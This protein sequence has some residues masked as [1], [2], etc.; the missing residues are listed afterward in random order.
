MYKIINIMFFLL[1]IGACIRFNYGYFIS[2]SISIRNHKNI[3][4]IQNKIQRNNNKLNAIFDSSSS[5]SNNDDHN[6]NPSPLRQLMKQITRPSDVMKEKSRKYRRTV[7]AYSDWKK[8]RSA[9][10]YI[11]AL[12]SWPRSNVLGG[13]II[14]AIIVALATA[15][16]VSWN[17]FVL[18]NQETYKLLGRFNLPLFSVPSLPFSLTSPSLGLLLVFRTNTAYSRWKDARIAWSTISSRTWD[19]MRQGVSW[20]P[21]AELKS[22]LVRHSSAYARTMKWH[23]SD[24]SKTHRLS[25]DLSSVVNQKEL[26]E[27]MMAR[28]KPQWA[29]L[30]I[31]DVI[32]RA[33]LLPNVQSHMDKNIVAMTQSYNQCE[34]IFS[35]PIPLVYTRH[36]VRFLFLWLITAPMAL[37][38]ELPKRLYWAIVPINTLHAIFL[39]GI[40]ELGV[41]IEEP[42]SILALGKISKEIKQSGED[43]LAANGLSWFG[44]SLTSEE[45]VQPLLLGSKLASNSKSSSK[46][47]SSPSSSPAVTAVAAAVGLT[48]D[49]ET[50]ITSI[51][52]IT[53]PTRSSSNPNLTP[54]T[55]REVDVSGVVISTDGDVSGTDIMKVVGDTSKKTAK[56]AQRDAR[57]ALKEADRLLKEAEAVA[58]QRESN[59]KSNLSSSSF[60][61]TSTITT[62]ATIATS[63]TT[64]GDLSASVG[65]H[66]ELCDVL[67]T[68]VVNSGDDKNNRNSEE[69]RESS[70]ISS[71]KISA[72]AIPSTY[73]P[74]TTAT[75]GSGGSSSSTTTPGNG[76]DVSARSNRMAMVTDDGVIQM[77]EVTNV[78]EEED[79]ADHSNPNP[80]DTKNNNNKNANALATTTS[81]SS[82]IENSTNSVDIGGM[83]MGIG[84]DMDATQGFDSRYT[85]EE[86]PGQNGTG[87]IDHDS[88]WKMEMLQSEL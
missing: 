82:T 48:T 83:N 1:I 25:D 64:T 61:T 38:H 27:Y 31:S 37:F 63:S 11:D 33:R 20:L 2:T 75:S 49:S 10:R 50:K 12:R 29:L 17:V 47:S 55:K 54:S 14:Q 6:E 87:N 78:L 19:L 72:S 65:T 53:T 30:K 45:Q 28:N 67:D 85:F 21:T 13:L 60:D 46:S 40:E 66:Q 44:E 86:T 9:R 15:A 35:T 43:I 8:H 41:Q 84:T 16:I 39:L 81:S 52:T 51:P 70:S 88:D 3:N 57:E 24:R 18:S 77:V 7:F 58:S 62:T 59:N 4:N 56:K 26:A 22:E 79:Y 80:T 71:E 5:S 34:R 42:F 36:T 69:M 76:P 73:A 23:L 68:V 32:R 74:W